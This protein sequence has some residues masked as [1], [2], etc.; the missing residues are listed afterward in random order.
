MAIAVGS[1]DVGG[2]EK[3]AAFVIGGGAVYESSGLGQLPHR[4][5]E[6]FLQAQGR[7]GLCRVATPKR[8][9]FQQPP[10]CYEAPCPP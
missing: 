6:D 9:P 10:C 1:E 7:R 5:V 8:L 4:Q 3:Y 2:E